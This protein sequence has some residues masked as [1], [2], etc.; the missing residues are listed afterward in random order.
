MIRYNLGI[1]P[2]GEDARHDGRS[3]G[4]RCAPAGTDARSDAP[5]WVLPAAP[6]LLRGLSRATL[7]STEAARRTW[8]PR[9]ATSFTYDREIHN[10]R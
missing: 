6:T 5:Q 7:Q 4:H 10:R 2:Y 8:R 1:V 3:F 9:C